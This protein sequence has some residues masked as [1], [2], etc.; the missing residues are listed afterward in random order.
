MYT[1]LKN[2]KT[3][4]EELAFCFEIFME[5]LTNFDLSTQKSQ[6]FVL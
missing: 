2:D 3:F 5:N 4:E 1:G 6:D